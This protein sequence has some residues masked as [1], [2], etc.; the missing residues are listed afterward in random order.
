MQFSRYHSRRAA[1]ER[2]L[3]SDAPDPKVA[4]VHTELADIHDHLLA[5]HAND[6]LAPDANVR[7]VKIVARS[8]R[9]GWGL[10]DRLWNA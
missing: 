1:A 7:Q 9:S 5:K 2:T 6:A 4:A 8:S 3:A 10:G